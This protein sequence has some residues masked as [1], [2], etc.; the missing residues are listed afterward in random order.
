M[1]A[2]RTVL[3]RTTPRRALRR[4]ER[5]GEAGLQLTEVVLELSPGL[6]DLGHLA[7]CCR[8]HRPTL[9]QRLAGPLDRRRSRLQRP[10]SDQDEH[11]GHEHE[12]HRHDQ[13]RCP[14]G[15]HHRQAG[16]ARRG[17]EADRVHPDDAGSGEHPRTR[18]ADSRR[19]PT[20]RSW[21]ARRVCGR[22]LW[23]PSTAD[24][25]DGAEWP[26]PPPVGGAAT[27][28]GI[29]FPPFSLPSA[30][31]TDPPFLDDARK[32][33]PKGHL[34]DATPPPPASGELSASHTTKNDRHEAGGAPRWAPSVRGARWPPQWVLRRWL[35][36]GR[37]CRGRSR[38]LPWGCEG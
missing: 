6:L 38:R 28:S 10:A 24:A 32:P 7:I 8:A 26:W 27:T 20:P 21:R 9:L 4:P 19:P 23:S 25:T 18:A 35:R 30:H 11:T 29:G 31:G 13:D 17:G 14:H 22:S 2:A 1:N 36:R 16:G 12:H 37:S 33:M 5:P 34:E 15:Q 3:P